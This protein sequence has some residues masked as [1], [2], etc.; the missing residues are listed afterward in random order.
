MLTLGFFL[1][2]F[3]SFQSLAIF[4]LLSGVTVLLAVVCE[5]FLLPALLSMAAMRGEGS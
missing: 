3:S 5:L 2:G 4:G 1:L